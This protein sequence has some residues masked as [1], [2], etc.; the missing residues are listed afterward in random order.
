MKNAYSA[1]KWR[2]K[3]RV[4]EGMAPASTQEQ[5][6]EIHDSRKEDDDDF[7]QWCEQYDASHPPLAAA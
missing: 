6:E 4:N 5:K 3:W 1:T 2:R 7:D